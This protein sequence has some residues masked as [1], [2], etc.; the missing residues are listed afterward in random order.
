MHG[1]LLPCEFWHFG[2]LYK[3]FKKFPLTQWITGILG[4]DEELCPRKEFLGMYV[5]KQTLELRVLNLEYFGWYR[6]CELVTY[7]GKI[8]SITSF[9]PANI[10][11]CNK[12][13]CLKMTISVQ[14][15]FLNIF[16]V[17]YRDKNCLVKIFF[18]SIISSF[19][20]I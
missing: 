17:I 18:N 12:L 19:R 7:F 10:N 9:C 1:I 3:L 2:I 4:Y 11:N 6:N 14:V 15:Y 16:R 5:I 20:D 8:F 13:K